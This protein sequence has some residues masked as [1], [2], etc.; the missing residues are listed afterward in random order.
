[1]SQWKSKFIYGMA[2]TCLVSACATTPPP[3]VDPAAKLDAIVAEADAAQKAGQTDKAVKLLKD[4]TSAFPADKGPWIRLA[5]IRFDAEN[6]GDAISYAL[7]G[8][9]RDPKDKVANSIVAVGGL[10]L[11]TKAL[12]DLRTQNDLNGNVRNEAQG[13]AKILRESLGETVLVPARPK[14]VVRPA[15][16][17]KG[18]V[19][20]KPGTTPEPSGDGANPFG[21]LQ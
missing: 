2:L 11:S 12:N 15:V 18:A 19:A 4:A 3:A 21:S 5:Q 17:K 13:L 10:R 8:L 7:E 20:A 1:M 14:A 9:N 6:Y 16:P